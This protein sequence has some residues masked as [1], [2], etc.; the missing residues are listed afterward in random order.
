MPW[1]NPYGWWAY[2][3]W[4]LFLFLGLGLTV[5][6]YALD[7]VVPKFKPGSRLLDWLEER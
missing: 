3:G 2:L 1:W 5:I 6:V 7:W 4:F